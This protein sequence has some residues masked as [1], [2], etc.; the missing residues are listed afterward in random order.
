MY[1]LL[2]R[3]ICMA[4]FRRVSKVMLL[5][6]SRLYFD[7]D[8]LDIPAQQ[9]PGIV[10]YNHINFAFTIMELITVFTSNITIDCYIVKNRLESEGLECFIYDENFIGV[11]PFRA[12]VSFHLN[13]DQ[14]QKYQYYLDRKNQI[15]NQIEIIKNT[16]SN[17]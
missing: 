10:S 16:T 14:Q 5:H 2:H 13:Q 1:W 11:N 15:D 17:N 9:M 3:L 6:Y 12:V 4:G 8:M 7:K